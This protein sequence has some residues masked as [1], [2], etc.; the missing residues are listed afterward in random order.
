MAANAQRAYESDLDLSVWHFTG[1]CP[2]CNGI[3]AYKYLNA[4]KPGFELKVMPNKKRFEVREKKI[5]GNRT[6]SL[7]T[8]QG[9]LTDMKTLLAA[10]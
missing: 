4:Q 10:V 9:S 3:L 1:Q 8:V 5:I 2:T 6:R 7:I